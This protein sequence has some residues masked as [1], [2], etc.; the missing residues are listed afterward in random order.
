MVREYATE[1]LHAKLFGSGDRF[2]L[3]DV[4]PH[5]SYVNRHIPGAI[6]IPLDE[7]EARAE[8]LPRDPDVEVITYCASPR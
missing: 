8:E 4:L 7:L 2:Y 1:E 6:G 5:D 3:V